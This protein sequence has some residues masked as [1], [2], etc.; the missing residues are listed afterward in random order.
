MIIMKSSKTIMEKE[1]NLTQ[2]MIKKLNEL[3]NNSDTNSNWDYS[4]NRSD[5]SD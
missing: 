2:T 3:E 1:F 5:G 4:E